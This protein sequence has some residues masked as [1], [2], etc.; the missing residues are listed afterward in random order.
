MDFSRVRAA[1]W[2]AG[3]WGVALLAVMFA[4]WYE[5]KMGVY[6]GPVDQISNGFTAWESF[7]FLDK[8]LALLGL[9]AVAI[10]FVTAARDSPSVPVAIDVV[11]RAVALI[12][13]VFVAY[14]LLNQPGPNDVIEIGWGAWA[15]L[16]CT[17]GTFIGAWWAMG[18]EHGPGL[19]PAPEARA[20]PAPPAGVDERA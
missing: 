18:T 1:D 2:V 12:A 16:L 5:P 7:G 3:A 15:G 19:R 14:R 10:P 8:L 11:T 13:I 9:L 6:F 17:L 4:R 20:M